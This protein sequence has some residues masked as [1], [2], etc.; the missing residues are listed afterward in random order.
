MKC[1]YD[2]CIKEGIVGRDIWLIFR[3]EDNRKKMYVCKE[4]HKIIERENI[5]RLDNPSKP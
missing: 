1:Q 4:H 2:K 3:L 5:R